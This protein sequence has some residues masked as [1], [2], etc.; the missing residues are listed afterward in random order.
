MLTD[1]QLMA[2]AVVASV[3]VWLLKLAKANVASGWLTVA[4]YVVS[5][6]L[7]FLFAPV[8]VPAFPA[9]VDLV[10]FVPAFIAWIGALL[11][12]LSA[13][14]GFATLIYNALL[15]A[16]LDKYALPFLKS[17]KK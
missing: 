8:A 15:K 6:V 17:F 4:V 14:V 9:Y 11:V 2:I 10:S 5:A 13:F 16:I 7:A 1:V 3:I 12:P